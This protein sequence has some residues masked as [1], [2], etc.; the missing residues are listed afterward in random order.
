MQI[1]RKPLLRI[2]ASTEGGIRLTPRGPLSPLARPII[3]RINRIFGQEKPVSAGPDRF[4]FS[5][6]IPPAPGLA[7][8]R[9]LSAQV[10][11]MIRRPIP[12]QISI[13]V[14]RACPNRCVHCSAPSREGDVLSGDLIRGVISEALEMG[15]Y[16]VTFDGGEPML[17]S[18]LP[19]LVSHVDGRAI[20]AA[21]TSGYHLTPELAERLKRAGLYAVRVSI[22]SPVEEEHDRVRG[23][24]GAFRDAL[25]GVRN[26]LEAGLL[27][28]L[29]MVTSP[30][31]ID[32]LDEAFSLAAEIG[33]HELS[34]YEIVAVGR[35][36]S[37]EDEVL[38]SE[39]ISRLESFHKRK[40]RADGPRVTALPY[41]MG[42]EMFG[43]FAGRRWIHVEASGEA[44]PCAYMPLGFGNI[45]ERS[46][47]DIWRD[48]S[49]YSWFSGRCS[50]RMKDP[51]FRASHSQKMR[52]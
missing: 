28:D 49:G 4:V 18:D 22:D 47:R 20:S 19:S 27:V 12:D 52:L 31:N 43:C 51:L 32:R 25:S 3:E 1:A 17:R 9:M 41:L 24:E 30:H 40:N 50:C 8:D 48:M 21:F 10:G 11:A 35:W 42:P 16:L 2:E 33:A 14:M 34:L 5:T 38:S 45:K 7:F 23:R 37:H 13:A 44:I 39:D 15:S 46:L 36:A 6:W 26:A 29:F